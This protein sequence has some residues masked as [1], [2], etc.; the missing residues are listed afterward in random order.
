MNTRI[1][2]A[3]GN[4]D[5]ESLA[6]SESGR[7]VNADIPVFVSEDGRHILA[8]GERHTGMALID[9]F[10]GES[11]FLSQEKGAGYYAGISPDERYVCYKT[12]KR[13]KDAI[14]QKSMLYDIAEKREI[15]LNDWTPLAGTPAV[16]RNSRIAFTTGNRLF[17]KDKDLNL[18]CDVD[19]KHHVNL[20]SF[21]PDGDKIAFNSKSEEIVVLDVFNK[22]MNV[23]SEGEE[24]F[25][26]PKFSPKGEKLLFQN[27][28]GKIYYK[29]LGAAMSPEI[30]GEGGHPEWIDEK[31]IR[32]VKKTIQNHQISNV[33]I[34][35]VDVESLVTRPIPLR[36][37]DADVAISRNAAC[38]NILGKLSLASFHEGKM[39]E[40]MNINSPALSINNI[41]N[42]DSVKSLFDKGTTRELEEVPVIHQVY[43]VSNWW[44]GHW[45][46][47]PT[48]A[49]MCLQ[50]YNILPK[51]AFICAHYSD[52]KSNYGF[53]IPDI[54]SFNGYTYDIGAWVEPA[55]ATAYGGHGFIWQENGNHTSVNMRDYFIQHGTSSA[56]DYSPTWAELQKEIMEDHPF[57]ILSLITSGGHYQSVIGYFKNQHTLI[58][59]DP[60]G[61]KNTPGYPTF[62]GQ[63]CLYDWPG[64]NNGYENLNTVSAYVFC[65]DSV[66]YPSPILGTDIVVDNDDGSPRYVETGT[67]TTSGNTGYNGGTYR[68]AYGDDSSTATWTCDL[69]Y[70]G[71]YEVFAIYRQDVSRATYV[72]YKITDDLGAHVVFIDQSGDANG[73]VETSLGIFGF[74][75]GQ[76]TVSL[77]CQGSAPSGNS[78]IADA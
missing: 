55:G 52:H 5:P 37:G 35:A 32:Y 53:Y 24:N 39:K 61:D 77:G 60:Y 78:V 7:I 30:I 25:W 3:Y 38:Y 28:S 11:L 74:H 67:W 15:P 64:Y 17:I 41:P 73:M 50:Y 19:L 10:T 8:T 22:T 27:I 57:V 71:D 21:S 29:D 46:C 18:I 1:P 49:M 66:S 43:D 51:H 44:W 33:E 2:T 9:A 40:I 58:V 69:V 12:F 63:R 4:H 65:R 59:N 13:T 48:A 68:Y 70:E 34:L 54:Y 42:D 72:R 36:K 26:G 62:D 14:L 45:S 23:I 75:K 16:S 20:L 31:N 47:G 56:V 76:Y 6:P